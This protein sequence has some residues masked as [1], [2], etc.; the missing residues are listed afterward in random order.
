MKKKS[1]KKLTQK[2]KIKLRR[3]TALAH[4]T[5]GAFQ[6]LGFVEGHTEHAALMRAAAQFDEPLF[7][8]K[9]V[10]HV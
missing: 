7:K 6:K 9:V 1:Y 10:R 2:Q 4:L 5:G 8:L 3:W